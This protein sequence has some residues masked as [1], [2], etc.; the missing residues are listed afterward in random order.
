M[1]KRWCLALVLSLILIFN[2][3]G[4]A[5]RP[6][7]LL[8]APQEKYFSIL[9]T[10]DEHSALLPS[11]LA[12]YHPELPNPSRGGF[13]RLAQAIEDMRQVKAKTSEPVLLISAGDYL[14]GSPFAWLAL[15]KKGPELS[16]L[17]EL[18]YDVATIGNHEYDF[19]PE[20][21]ANYLRAAGYPEAAGKTAIV[22]TNTLPPAGHPLGDLPLQKTHIKVLDNGLK[23]GFFGIL[24]KDAIKVA[25]NSKPIEFADQHTA[26]REAV[27]QLQK[28]GADVI[29]AVN[30][31][32]LK[33]DRELARAVPGIH[34]IVSGH[35]HTA[36]EEPLVENGVIIVQA[37]ELLNYLGILELAYNPATKEV[38][39]RNQETVRPY[40]L[41]LDDKVPPHREM[42]GRLAEII[43]DLNAVVARVSNGRFTDIG[44][45]LMY[46]DFTVTN[47]PELAESPFGNFVAD[48]MRS[49]AEEATGQRVHFAFQANGLIRGALTPGSASHAK[50]QV[51]FLDLAGLVGLGSGPDGEPGYPLVSVYLTGEEVRRILEVSVLLSELMGDSYYLQV[52]GLSMV[53]DPKRAILG[54]VP[55]KKIPVPTTRA[56]LSAKKHVGSG[57]Q[58][59]S[60][61]EPLKRG[62]QE[63][64]HVVSDYYI[65]SFLPMVGKMLPQLGLVLK[66]KNGNPIADIKNAIIYRDGKELKVWQCV[67]EYA[68]AQ[69]KDALG[70]PR[71]PEHYAKTA[72][73]LV[74]VNTVPLLVYPGLGL[75]LALG[76]LTYWI[77]RRRRHPRALMQRNYT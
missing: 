45:T 75:A 28:D 34:V 14:G 21:L 55:V 32:G 54:W 26:A 46:S 39:V 29:V 52:S 76:L 60:A 17:I 67:L 65:A 66:D 1:K 42:S 69:P 63:L 36:L 71:M 73:R 3:L 12:D 41:P 11:P 38:R 43:A 53:Y 62:D 5:L 9:H 51:A 48:A 56:V 70:N 22:A 27:A 47:R 31:A 58:H 57:I 72:G 61:M 50:G 33:E 37:G 15:D 40:L 30:H 77:I 20:V 68:Q 64:Y 16:L 24:G 13:A 25:P 2:I 7:T 19:G 59:E 23:V 18:G 74:V 10:N 44:E 49:I 35:C 8:A 4:Q 6:E